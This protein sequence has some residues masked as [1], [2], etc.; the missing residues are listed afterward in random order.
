VFFIRTPHSTPALAPADKIQPQPTRLT[1][2]QQ[3]T[4]QKE[5]ATSQPP[6][7]FYTQILR[8]ATGH[9]HSTGQ[10]FI[11]SIW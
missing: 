11:Q 10:E 5:L 6:Q 1:K 8:G 9:S 2:N 3:P 7:H 4:A